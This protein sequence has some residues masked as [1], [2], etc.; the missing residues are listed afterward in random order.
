MVLVCLICILDEI[1]PDLCTVMLLV[2]VV[3]MCYMAEDLNI[4]TLTVHV[5]ST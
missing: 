3:L 1:L 4:I 2:S 5:Y